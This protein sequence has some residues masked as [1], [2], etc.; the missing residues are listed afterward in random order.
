M[1]PLTKDLLS[2][3]REWCEQQRGR[4]SMVARY[5]DIDPQALSNLFAG[6][7]QLTGEQALAIQEF[8]K[9]QRRRKA[10]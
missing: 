4:K 8:L 1:E 3:L 7:Q 10:K 9:K 2:K 5:L 6:R